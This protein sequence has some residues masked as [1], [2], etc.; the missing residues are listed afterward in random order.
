M[1]TTPHLLNADQ[2]AERRGVDRRTITRWA[3]SGKLPVALRLPGKTGALLFAVT[4]VD[5]A[6]LSPAASSTGEASDA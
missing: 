2:A 4:D 3:S 6:P 5:R 1:T